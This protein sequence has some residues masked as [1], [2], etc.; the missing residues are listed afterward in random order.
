MFLARARRLFLLHSAD[1]LG[2]LGSLCAVAT[3]APL[4]GV[5][6]PSILKEQLRRG[7]KEGT[8][9]LLVW[10]S[11]GLNAASWEATSAQF[12]FPLRDEAFSFLSTLPRPWPRAS[13]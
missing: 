8:L 9:A 4:E 7:E 12:V 10:G 5:W 13:L 2:W 3:A 6:G 11:G 1:A